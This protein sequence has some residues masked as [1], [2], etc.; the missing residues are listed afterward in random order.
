[1]VND[2]IVAGVVLAGIA[3]NIGGLDDRLLVVTWTSYGFGA[4]AV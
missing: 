3:R 1:M 4:V 2:G